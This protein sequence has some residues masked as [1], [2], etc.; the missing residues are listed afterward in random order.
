MQLRQPNRRR[1]IAQHGDSG[2]AIRP[3]RTG[4]D[5][6][7]DDPPFH[8]FDQWDHRGFSAFPDPFHSRKAKVMISD[9]ER[10]KGRHGF[11]DAAVIREIAIQ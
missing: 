2:S 3:A 4:C 7:R 8:A 11:L 1:A 6:I 9:A 10:W 5:A